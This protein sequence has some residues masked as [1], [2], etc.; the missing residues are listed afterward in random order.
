MNYSNIGNDRTINNATL[1]DIVDITYLPNLSNDT[2]QIREDVK[3]GNCMYVWINLLMFRSHWI[4]LYRYFVLCSCYCIL[5]VCD[6]VCVVNE[7]S[8]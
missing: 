3:Q 8:M 5:I 1:L 4:L 2:C 7:L 6:G